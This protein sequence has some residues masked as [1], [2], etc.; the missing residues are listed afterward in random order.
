MKCSVNSDIK[1]LFFSAQVHSTLLVMPSRKHYLLLAHNEPAQQG[2]TNFCVKFILASF[3]IFWLFKFS[4]TWS[5]MLLG[6]VTRWSVCMISALLPSF[7]DILSFT[8]LVQ[9]LRITSM[10][11]RLSHKNVKLF[12]S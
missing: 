4:E 8:C 1:P 11:V 2:A 7:Q 10:Q 9:F 3:S 5:L 6:W 12:C